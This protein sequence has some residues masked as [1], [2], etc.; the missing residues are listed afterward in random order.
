MNGSYNEQP[1]VNWGKIAAYGAGSVMA[2]GMMRMGMRGFSKAAARGKTAVRAQGAAARRRAHRA[3]AGIRSARDEFMAGARG[4]GP[5]GPQPFIGPVQRN[6]FKTSKYRDH[7]RRTARAVGAPP[8]PMADLQALDPFQRSRNIGSPPAKRHAGDGMIRAADPFQSAANIP[9][10]HVRSRLPTRADMSTGT[11][12]FVNRRKPVRAD[13]G[14]LS[15]QAGARR[16]PFG[17]IP[18]GLI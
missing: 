5:M 10:S 17:T 7:S 15:Y 4:Q 9:P 13:P 6:K 18:T 16:S 11:S 1:G 8:R 14:T 2:V 3:G 12:S